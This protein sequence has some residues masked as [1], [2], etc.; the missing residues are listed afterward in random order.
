[1]QELVDR[2]ILK[3]KEKDGSSVPAIK[4][5]HGRVSGATIFQTAPDD[6]A[7]HLAKIYKE[8]LLQRDDCLRTL[9]QLKK[10]ANINERRRQRCAEIDR[11]RNINNSRE[12]GPPRRRGR[13]RRRT[14]G[15]PR[16]Q[17]PIRQRGWRPRYQSPIR[18]RDGH[19][20]QENRPIQIFIC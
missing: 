12:D 9:R 16:S 14:S 5:Y 6:S 8:F 13:G 1:M 3:L 17:G 20:H 7:K 11:R 15:R 4:S 2:A 10:I 19:G 18:L